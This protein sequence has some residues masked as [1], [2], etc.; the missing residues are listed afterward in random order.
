MK[1]LY[2]KMGFVDRPA[3]AQP[4]SDEDIDPY[5]NA[6]EVKREQKS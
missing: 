4:L 1:F 5:A 2:P 6:K 3:P